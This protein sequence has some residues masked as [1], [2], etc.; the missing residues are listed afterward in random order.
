MTCRGTVIFGG[1]LKPLLST[2]DSTAMSSKCSKGVLDLQP[3]PEPEGGVHRICNKAISL[4]GLPH[5][6]DNV[7]GYR[8]YAQGLC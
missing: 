2:P 6:C 8:V 7:T 4:R 5:A 1:F 3:G